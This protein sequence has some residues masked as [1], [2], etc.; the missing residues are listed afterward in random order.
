MNKF[1]DDKM[2]LLKYRHGE[3]DVIHDGQYVL[4]GISGKRIEISDI[5]YWSVD[6]QEAYV[7][8]E[9]ALEAYKKK[10]NTDK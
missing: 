3:F 10:T 5:K 2:A 9:F 4:C 6:K 1:L 7:S 8:P